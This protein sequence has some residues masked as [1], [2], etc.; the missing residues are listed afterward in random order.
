VAGW[1]P[2][3]GWPSPQGWGLHMK[4]R[5]CS[6]PKRLAGF[7]AA[8]LT[9]ALGATNANATTYIESVNLSRPQVQCGNF[10]G[11]EL[12][13]E[14]F[15]FSSPRAANV[16]DVYKIQVTMDHPLTLPASNSTD[17]FLVNLIDTAVT[18]LGPG[19]PGPY[20]A[21]SKLVMNGYSGPA[22]P[23]AGGGTTSWNQGYF[24]VAGFCCGYGT[25][26]GGFSLTGADAQLTLKTADPNGLAG[27]A[28]SY[29]WVPDSAAVP[30]PGA[31]AL[32]IAGS[33]M[34]GWR[35]R[36]RSLWAR[37]SA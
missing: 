31:W 2:K 32:M 36:R 17:I 28:V 7:G 24:A 14:F 8:A 9:A 18:A 12:C 3:Y 35:L 4:I 27:M 11:E 10:S 37:A 34:I 5:N 20:L 22:A 30:E 15:A 33:G 26:N 25:P 29:A 21:K 6:W 1:G 13:T 23:I 16:G 19:A